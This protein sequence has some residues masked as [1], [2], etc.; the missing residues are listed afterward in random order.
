MHVIRRRHGSAA[1]EARGEACGDA[2]LGGRRDRLGAE[3]DVDEGGAERLVLNGLRITGER[4]GGDGQRV[5][6][7]G[8]GLGLGLGLESELGLGLGV[9]NPNPCS[10]CA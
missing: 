10:L 3:V 1:V 7:L 5:T 2:R 8:L 6:W 9:A 4:A